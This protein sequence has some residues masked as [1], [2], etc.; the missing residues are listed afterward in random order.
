MTRHV[1]WALVGVDEVGQILGNELIEVGVQ[2][3]A[4]RRVGVFEEDEAAAR[5]LDKDRG[6]AF[7]K[8][9]ARDAGLDFV[10]DFVGA[11]AARVD[12]EAFCEGFHSSTLL[13]TT[14]LPSF[15]KVE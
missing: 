14:S 6:S 3:L 8:P 7:R 11:F 10:T 9:S 5:V 12:G 2:V 13:T 15:L 1:V 4:R